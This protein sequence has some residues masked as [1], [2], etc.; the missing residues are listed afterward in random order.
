MTSQV[1][2][3]ALLLIGTTVEVEVSAVVVSGLAEA[4]TSLT[5]DEV[6]VVTGLGV[7]VGVGAVSS[8]PDS[9]TFATEGAFDN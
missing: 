2:I 9:E 8:K 7:A 4:V 6:D 5:D 1:G 3:Q